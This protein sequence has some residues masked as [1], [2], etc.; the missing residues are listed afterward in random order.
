MNENG[1]P[2]TQSAHASFSTAKVKHP[3]GVTNKPAAFL[4]AGALLI[5]VRGQTGP[6]SVTFSEMELLLVL[7]EGSLSA[8]VVLFLFSPVNLPSGIFP[9]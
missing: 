8:P 9:L 2:A 6:L 1:L 7:T 5:T 3:S 4:S